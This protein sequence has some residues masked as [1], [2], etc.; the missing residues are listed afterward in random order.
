MADPDATGIALYVS[1][2]VAAGGIIAKA[3]AAFWKFGNK[4]QEALLAELREGKAVL[5][6]E[7]TRLQ[8]VVESLGSKYDA[9]RDKREKVELMFAAHV[10]KTDDYEDLPSKVQTIALTVDPSKQ[11]PPR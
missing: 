1:T 2:G 11:S 4:G 7:N 5:A 10:V 9:E 3:I 6:A 8:G